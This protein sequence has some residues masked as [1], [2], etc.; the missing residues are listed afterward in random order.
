MKPKALC[1]REWLT[2]SRAAKTRRWTAGWRRPPLRTAILRRRSTW[3]ATRG[4][5][6]APRSRTSST[7]TTTPA[8]TGGTSDR[9][10]ASWS[11]WKR[12]SQ[13]PSSRSRRWSTGTSGCRRSRTG[14]WGSSRDPRSRPDP[15]TSCCS[16]RSRLHTS[17]RTYNFYAPSTNQGSRADELTSGGG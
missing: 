9:P 8:G 5:C 7:A 17:T 11:G 1:Y 13:P 14:N 10:S 2:Y 3:L 15:D 4:P 12:R 16:H 6:A